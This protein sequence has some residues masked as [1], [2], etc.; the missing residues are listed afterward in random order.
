MPS[1]LFLYRVDLECSQHYYFGETARAVPNALAVSPMW[2]WPGMQPTL[3]LW[4]NSKGCAECPRCFPCVVLAW[5]AAN[6]TTLE[7]QQG[8]CPMPSLFLLCSVG[9]ECSQH[10][11]FG[12]TARA[13]H[14]ALAVSPM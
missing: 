6:T 10:Y 5:N 1:L 4:I 2:C 13:V 7:K 12:E 3:L 11:Y 14:N 9:L 8:Q